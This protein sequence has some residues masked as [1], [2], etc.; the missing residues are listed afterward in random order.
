MLAV[1][2]P[3][4]SSRNKRR[5]RSGFIEAMSARAVSSAAPRLS[6]AS[7]SMISSG[8]SGIEGGAPPA[9]ASDA[10]LASFESTMKQRIVAKSMTSDNVAVASLQPA[11]SQ[12]PSWPHP[13]KT[14]LADA[15][16]RAVPDATASNL[17]S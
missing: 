9:A 7:K 5:A 4:R 15:C 6:I 11:S 12:A 8:V 10:R 2:G 3:Y 13:R 14:R 17:R 1:G 16:R